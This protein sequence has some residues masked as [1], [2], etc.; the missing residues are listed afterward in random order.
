M[1][2]VSQAEEYIVKTIEE[3]KDG[4]KVRK[5]TEPEVKAF[6]IPA[7]LVGKKEEENI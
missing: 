3:Y 1:N 4:Q 6:G 5:L 7:I 2:S